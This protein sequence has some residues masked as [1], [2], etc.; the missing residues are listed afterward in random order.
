[1]T[2]GAFSQDAE[3]DP[4]GGVAHEVSVS[5]DDCKRLVAHV[6]SDDVAFKPGVDVRGK[7]VTPAEGPAD[8]ATLGAIDLPDEIVIDFGYDFA[9]AYGIPNTGLETAT[10][11]ILTI[12]YDL[13]LGGLAINGKPLTKSDAR[14]VAKACELMLKGEG[15]EGR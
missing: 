6:P 15:G 14:A 3:L 7:A 2:N 9:G 12:S 13:E 4:L 8:G 5:L 11:N 1:M 10:A